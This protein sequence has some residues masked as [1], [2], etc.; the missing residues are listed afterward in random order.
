M[1]NSFFSA[2]MQGVDQAAI[3]AIG[4]AEA[5]VGAILVAGLVITIAIW[6]YGKI[7]NAI[8]AN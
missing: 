5:A 2:G 3:T 6:S 8:R 7:K 1:T 4:T